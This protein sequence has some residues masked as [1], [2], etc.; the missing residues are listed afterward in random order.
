MPAKNPPK[1]VKTG[2]RGV[3]RRGSRYVVVYYDGDG[4]Q[5]KESAR[6]LDEARRLKA[7]RV[8]QVDEGEFSPESNVTLHTYFREWV[9]RYQGKGRN[10]FR[11]N[12]RDDY[13][14]Q[15]EAYIC[16]FFP[17]RLRLKEVTPVRIAKFVA[18]LCDEEQQDRVLADATVRN[19]TAPLRA[20]LATAMKEGLIRSN[21]TVGMDLPHRQT[22][23]DCE[24]EE[25]KA[26]SEAE[27]ATLLGLLPVA[28][29]PFFSF[30]AA[31]GLRISEAV[32]LQWRHV[33]LDGSHAH[34]KV[35][36]ALVKGRMGP[37]KSRHGR[38]DVPLDA[39][40]VSALR[41]L[42]GDQPDDAPVFASSTGTPLTPE[43]VFRRV[44]QPA[45]E[46]ACLEWVG[47][48]AFRHTCA[49]M[50]FAQGRNVKQVQR[51]LG[52]HS[53][54]FTLDTYVHLL[55]GDLG[56]PLSV[57]APA[58]AASDPARQQRELAVAP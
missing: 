31:T 35:R 8:T 9:E 39:A 32:A 11:E 50:L 22:A 6:T 4:K 2:T 10:G 45:R 5:R 37:P 43:N 23:T 26:M 55:D 3:Y 58:V 53:P 14:R 44:L 36:R 47:F 34:V 16:E 24:E 19:I 48:H 12:T 57:P 18:W 21:P 52:H 41:K 28:W 33:Q 49:S 1:M 42:R 46:E 27:L 56:E 15:G 29:Q 25:A 40:Q 30:L 20:C 7:K 54:S 13:R 51:W 38:R 17:A